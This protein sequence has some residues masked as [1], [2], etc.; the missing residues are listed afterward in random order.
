MLN[1][2]N[3]LYR[4]DSCALRLI[5]RFKNVCERP[6]LHSVCRKP[7]INRDLLSSDD[8]ANLLSTPRGFIF[9]RSISNSKNDGI[10]SKKYKR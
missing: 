1:T 7:I 5:E 4:K 3:Q 6:C 9:T 2:V 8:Y 10:K